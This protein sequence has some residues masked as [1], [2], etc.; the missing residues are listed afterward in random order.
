MKLSRSHSLCPLMLVLWYHV[1][2]Q[3]WGRK[4]VVDEGETTNLPEKEDP[5]GPQQTRKTK[6]RVRSQTMSGLYPDNGSLVWAHSIFY[7]HLGRQTCV[8]GR[9][10]TLSPARRGSPGQKAATT[11]AQD[12]C[13]WGRCW[14]KPS[15]L[16]NSSFSVFSA[17]K[18]DLGQK[19]P[20]KIPSSQRHHN[21]LFDFEKQKQK[22]DKN[23]W[24]KLSG[25]VNSSFYRHS[26]RYSS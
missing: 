23:T 8:R 24:P 9:K 14:G 20:L 1:L 5:E 17:I 6:R 16:C 12:P 2:S 26:G 4:L 11:T 19:K 22:R 3:C 10:G 21:R 25:P 18:C 13:N 15:L 7:Y